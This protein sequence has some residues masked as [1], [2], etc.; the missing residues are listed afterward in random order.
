MIPHRVPAASSSTAGQARSGSVRSDDA[1]RGALSRRPV[2][3]RSRSRRL[4][5]T[6][7]AISHLLPTLVPLDVARQATRP[8][9]RTQRG[10]RSARA[11]RRA[12]THRIRRRD[13]LS[14]RRIFA[15]ALA[16]AEEHALDVAPPQRINRAEMMLYTLV[17]H[18]GARPAPR[19]SRSGEVAFDVN[20]PHRRRGVR[21]QWPFH[22]GG[23]GAQWW[24]GTPPH[25][26]AKA[27]A[28]PCPQ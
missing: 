6:C 7:L 23:G 20:P 5:L 14:T 19:H 16:R 10:M 18:D 22:G 17:A 21:E 26:A 8:S 28:L 25:Q 11:V 1:L 4:F 24:G 12:A 13:R 3:R 27:R 2:V 9:R 15:V